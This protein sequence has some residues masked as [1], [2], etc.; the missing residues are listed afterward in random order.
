MND[1][2][3]KIYKY[4][5]KSASHIRRQL[6]PVFTGGIHQVG[7]DAVPAKKPDDDDGDGDGP[8]PGSRCVSLLY[9]HITAYIEN[10][11][12]QSVMAHSSA[13]LFHPALQ[14]HLICICDIF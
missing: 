2:A 10:I 9:P 8:P 14:K 1:L 12:L 3:H 13:S 5:H 7:K 11:T 6:Y 4:N